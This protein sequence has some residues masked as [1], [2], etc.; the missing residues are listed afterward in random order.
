MW[1]PNFYLYQLGNWDNPY[2]F[3]SLS[4]LKPK[5]RIIM[6]SIFLGCRVLS[7]VLVPIKY[8]VNVS[9]GPLSGNFLQLSHHS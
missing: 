1:A 2:S 8:W 4:F 3:L 7:T 9:Y 6:I 5:V